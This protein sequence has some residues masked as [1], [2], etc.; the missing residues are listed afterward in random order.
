[1]GQG[2]LATKDT[3]DLVLP[4]DKAIIKA[5]TGLDIPW[6]DLHHRSYFLPELRRIEVGEFVSTMN[7]DKSCSINPLDTHEVYAEGN[8]V[9]ITTTFILDIS[10]TPSVV[11]NFF[12]GVDCSHE[13]IQNYTEL[14][15]QLCDVFSWSYE[16]ILGIDPRIVKHEITT[17]PNAKPVR[18]ELLPVNPRK[19]AAIKVEVEK[20]LKYGFNYPVQLTEWVSNPI[21]INKK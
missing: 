19:E 8:M 6:D 2:S 1:L 5:L 18:Q 10:K 7:G 16:E 11:E 3:L 14:F 15:K 21:P 4:S 17:Y 12:V 20:F 13:D 9:S